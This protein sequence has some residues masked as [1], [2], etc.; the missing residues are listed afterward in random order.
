MDARSRAGERVK[1]SYVPKL[2]AEGGLQ[3]GRR[4]RSLGHHDP[5]DLAVGSRA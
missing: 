1:G 5:R 2:H 4:W 3:D